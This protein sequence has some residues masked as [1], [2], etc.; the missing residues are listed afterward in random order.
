MSRDVFVEPIEAFES[1]LFQIQR[2]NL[3]DGGVHKPGHGSNLIGELAEVQRPA[4]DGAP[5]C[6]ARIRTVQQLLLEERAVKGAAALTR[7]W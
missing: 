5:L 3:F 4:V 7:E 1:H 6:G 2:C